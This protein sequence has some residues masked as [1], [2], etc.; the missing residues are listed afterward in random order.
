MVLMDVAFILEG[1]IL[2]VGKIIAKTE[3]L[4]R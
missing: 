4:R 1:M 2:E 3:A